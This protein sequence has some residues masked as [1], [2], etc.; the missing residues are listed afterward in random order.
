MPRPR[1]VMRKIREVLRL[2]CAEGLSRR[3]TGIAAG[4]PT[5]TVADY[6]AQ[7]QRASLGRPV[8]EGRDDSQL[9]ARLFLTAGPP[10]HNRPQPDWSYVHR[11]LRRPHVTLQ[12]L[13]LE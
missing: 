2:T 3:L 1:S 12:L 13:H 11:E 10:Q 4:L 6:V 8:P 5:T 9:E 7:A